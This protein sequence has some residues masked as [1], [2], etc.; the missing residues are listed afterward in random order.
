M[1]RSLLLLAFMFTILTRTAAA[2]ARPK[3]RVQGRVPQTTTPTG[4]TY[5]NAPLDLDA[6]RLPPGYMGNDPV[7]IYNRL[8][9]PRKSEFETTEAYTARTQ[10]LTREETFA[11]LT[12]NWPVGFQTKYDA[13]S[14]QMLVTVQGSSGVHE[15]YSVDRGRTAF[16]FRD[17]TVSSTYTGSNA[18]GAK[19]D[20]SSLSSQTYS[21]IPSCA[22]CNGLEHFGQALKFSTGIATTRTYLGT[23]YS[24]SLP[25]APEVA[26]ALSG[27]FGGGGALA[28]SRPR[29]GV[30]IV[31]K[32]DPGVQPVAVS[33]F[34]HF[35]P[36]MDT[37]IEH[38]THHHYIKARVLQFWFFDRQTGEILLKDPVKAE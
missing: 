27:G 23:K 12:G 15:G 28:H 14:K 21:L 3:H 11:F 37:P 10:Y 1:K 19:V 4:P 38:T 18:F 36:T 24:V 17:D 32:T 13:D 2:Q 7:G 6:D 26:E 9:P 25:L 31:C 30:L 33:G 20:V 29:L 35:T 8:I 34:E 5:S 16:V 22:Y